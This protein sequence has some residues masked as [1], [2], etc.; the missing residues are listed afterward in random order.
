MYVYNCELK[1]YSIKE[2]NESLEY[3]YFHL[4][5]GFIKKKKKYGGI[6]HGGVTPPS[7]VESYF[8]NSEKKS[9]KKLLFFW[10]INVLKHVLDDTGNLKMFF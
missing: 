6:F 3:F 9:K 2:I 1:F 5:E 4:R 10:V 7:S 8:E